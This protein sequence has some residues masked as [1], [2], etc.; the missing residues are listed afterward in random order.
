M[1]VKDLFVKKGFEVVDKAEPDFEL[2]VIKFKKDAPSPRFKG[3]WDKALAKYDKGLTILW[4]DQ[5]LYIAK[6]IGEI[7]KTIKERYK[8]K[9]NIVRAVGQYLFSRYSG[10]VLSLLL[11]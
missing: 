11:K 8:I 9:A 1:I 2:L 5:C 4:S 6:S 7:R 10:R 3:N